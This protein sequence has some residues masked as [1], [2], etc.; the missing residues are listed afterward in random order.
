MVK[1]VTVEQMRVIEQATDAA[2]VSYDEMMQHAGRSV[3][4]VVMGL[5]DELTPDRRVAVLVGPGNNGGDG[6]VAARVLKEETDLEVGCYLFKPRGDDDPVYVAARD[7][8][9][10]IALA[11]DDQRWRTLKTLIGNADIVV[12][13]LLGTGARLPVT[14]DLKKLIEMASRAIRRDPPAPAGPVRPASPSRRYDR[15]ALVVAVDCPSGLDCDTGEL[16]PV[17][18]PADV[19]VTF[20]AA[21]FGLLAFP[22]AEAVGE[23]VVADINTPPKLAELQAITTELATGEVIREMLPPRPSDAH[24]GTFG[25]VVAVAGSVNYTGAA[26]LAGS[27][28][29]RVGA[30]LVTMAV[31]QIIYPMLAP[32]LP[33]ATWLLLP[34]DMGAIN[35]AAVGVLAEEMGAVDALLIGPGLG[36]DE[37]TA[38]F[39]RGLLLGEEQAKR[40]SIGFVARQAEKAAGAQVESPLSDSLVIDADGLNL[41]AEIDEWWALLPP[42]TVLTPHPGEMARLTGLDRE[43]IQGDRVNV[44]VEKATEWTCVVVL[45]GA[46]TVVAEPEGRA[47]VL[48]FATDTLATGGTG[49]VLTGA[50][51]GLMAQGVAPFDAAVAG[52]YVHGLA[53]LIAGQQYTTR[54]VIAGDVLRALPEALSRIANT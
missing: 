50:I 4:E 18:I 23:L 15:G 47:V 11:D 46:F 24:K 28:A 2:G 32:Q 26:V 33:E 39:M 37:N 16:D 10:F 45:K 43:A 21:K 34:H 22:G 20:A 51:A 17:A 36:R 6:L 1:I 19:T 54:S 7:A 5:L 27:A 52:A 29:Y 41:L 38:E 14:G 12:D 42:H 25:R 13:A 35:A 49:D 9:V 8:D 3:A 40:G 30:G 31:P 48:P 53:G 44:A